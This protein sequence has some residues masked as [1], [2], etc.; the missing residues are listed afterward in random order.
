MATI[1][2]TDDGIDIKLGDTYYFV[3]KKWLGT[4]ELKVFSRTVDEHYDIN[5]KAS[6][7]Y[8]IKENAEKDAESTLEYIS[9]LES[10]SFEGWSE[11]SIDGYLT[12]CKS[13][14]EKLLSIKNIL[15][16]V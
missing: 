5:K 8:G 12:A 6:T 16:D 3:T 7:T 13:I 14:K 9:K 2:T 1:F 11:E 10:G 15:K 4:D